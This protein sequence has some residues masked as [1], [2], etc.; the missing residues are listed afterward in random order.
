LSPDRT[1]ENLAQIIERLQAADATVILAGMRVPANYG[2]EYTRAF[3][4]VF[5]EL[6]R[7]YRLA[8]IPFF[9][10]GVATEPALNQS[11]GLHPTADGYRVIVDRIWPHIRPLLTRP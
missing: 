2:A 1:R 5:P 8:F 4:A 3:E 6:A 11:D 10:D 7:R 9:L